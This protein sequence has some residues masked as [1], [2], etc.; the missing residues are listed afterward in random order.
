MP[1]GSVSSYAIWP[2]GGRRLAEFYAAALG[3]EVGGAPY[4]DGLGNEAASPSPSDQPS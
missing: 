2:D 4:P 3:S 1:T